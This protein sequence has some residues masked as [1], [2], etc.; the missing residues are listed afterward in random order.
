MQERSPAF[1]SKWQRLLRQK[2]KTL[3]NVAK[4]RQA[5]PEDKVQDV[6]RQARWIAELLA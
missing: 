5:L 1:L 6:A 2:H 3:S 4:A